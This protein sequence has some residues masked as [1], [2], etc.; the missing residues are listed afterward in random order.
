MVEQLETMK[1][2]WAGC[3]DNGVLRD[4]LVTVEGQLGVMSSELGNY[5]MQISQLVEEK[6]S[7]VR[8]KEE[9]IAEVALLRIKLR[10]WERAGGSEE[11]TDAL[12]TPQ[13][14]APESVGGVSPI[15]GGHHPLRID[16]PPFE[17][18]VSSL[19]H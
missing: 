1:C 13:G 15:V 6:S 10:R 19:G 3:S 11:S 12:L 4:K 7:L 8:D 5:K 14:H 2:E 18:T 9:L 16:A 17:P